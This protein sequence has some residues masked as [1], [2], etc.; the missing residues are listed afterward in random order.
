[1]GSAHDKFV[2]KYNREPN[3]QELAEYKAKLAAK[4]EKKAREAEAS[5]AGASSSAAPAAEV[6]AAPSEGGAKVTKKRK[7]AVDAIA[8]ADECARFRTAFEAASRAVAVSAAIAISRG[9]GAAMDEET[10]A[11]LWDQVR[12]NAGQLLTDS[13]GALSA[14][15]LDD[16]EREQIVAAL[17][18]TLAP[19]LQP[20]DELLA[21]CRAKAPKAKRVKK[22][23]APKAVPGVRKPNVK[24]DVLQ[25]AL[26]KL[27]AF[28]FD[29]MDAIGSTSAAHLTADECRQ[30]A[31]EKVRGAAC[32]AVFT[33]VRPPA[34]D[35]LRSRPAHPAYSRARPSEGA[36]RRPSHFPRTMCP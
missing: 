22:A 17:R 33:R 8:P 14:M 12:A 20:T 35:H 1:M 16:P 27:A 4:K 10:F 6:V 11:G 13:E 7:R 31:I 26:T 34:R 19:A 30:L 36:G 28:N 3:A 21:E 24:A 5:T 23:A 2:K 15:Q 29:L 32:P 25:Q 18:E 9:E